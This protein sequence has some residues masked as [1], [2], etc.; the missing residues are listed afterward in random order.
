MTDKSGRKAQSTLAPANARKVKAATTD[1][2]IGIR[3]QFVAIM[4][5][6]LNASVGQDDLVLRPVL[7]EARRVGRTATGK[8]HRIDDKRVDN[9]G[10]NK[11]AIYLSIVLDL[12]TLVLLIGEYF[13]TSRIG[14]QCLI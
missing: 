8:D 11:T 12:G 10:A 1:G 5:A 2:G 6:K 7:I 9:T 3:C 13:V 4:S 14:R